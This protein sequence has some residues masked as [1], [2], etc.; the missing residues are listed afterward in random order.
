[1]VGAGL[2]G[3]V[4]LAVR[5]KRPPTPSASWCDGSVAGDERPGRPGAASRVPDYSGLPLAQTARMVTAFRG[6]L[7]TLAALL[8]LGTPAGAQDE[9]PEV[10]RLNLIGVESV[11][12]DQLSLS[13]ATQ[14]SRCRG[15]LLVPVCWITRSPIFWERHYL[16][17]RELARDIARIQAFY[18]R[19][20]WRETEVDT[21][22]APRGTNRAEVTFRIA[23]GP[24]T[25]VTQ[26]DVVQTQ[27]VLP[28][29]DLARAM[30][31]QVGQPLNLNRVDTTRFRLEQGLQERGYADA[32]V[33]TNIV[34]DEVARAATV[35]FDVNPRWI[36]TVE[37]INVLE[38]QRVSDRTILRSL[39]FSE[40]D[41]FR[42]TDL[43]RSQRNLYESNLFRRAVISPEDGP[44]DSAK[45][46]EITVT[47]APL[48]E[49]R[50]SAGFSTVDFL[51]TETR[52]THFNFMGGA[53]RLTVQG[54]IGNLL[55]EQLNDRLIF[56]NVFTIPTSDR[57]RY[58]SPTYNASV[59]LRQPWFLSSR[60]DLAANAFAS[61]RLQPGI[62]VDRSYGGA[63]TFTREIMD[64]TPVSANYRFEV[65]SVEAGDVYFCVNYGVCDQPTLVA[66]RNNQ[67]LSPFSLIGRYDRTNDPL[68]PSR[69]SR[70][71][72]DTE[73]ASQTTGSDY[74]YNRAVLEGSHFM[75]FR[76][77]GVLA[78][79]G[80]AGWV[81]ALPS[82]GTAVTGTPGRHIL[83][84]RKRFYSG[85]ANSVRGFR[86][87]QLGPRVLTIA[88]E[89]LRDAFAV[90][91]GDTVFACPSAVPIEQC[92]PGAPGLRD[93][94]FEGR[95][96]GGNVVSEAS[97]ELR[98]P[99]NRILTGAVFV[100]GGY[101]AQRVD[102]TLP[103]SRAGITPG[104]GIRYQSAIGP[105]RV[106]LGINPARREALPVITEIVENGERRLIRLES[107][108]VH[109]IAR[110][111]LAGALDRVRLH[112]SIGEAF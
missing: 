24:P 96:I 22:V 38:N 106:D 33:D 53:R 49:A 84:P 97:V 51:Q 25:I 52:F 108:R 103:S 46:V 27:D 21:A 66:L 111:G 30:A 5:G 105:I 45:V 62:F 81:E 36:A 75:Q 43:L 1:M 72:I 83:H 104:F 23:E 34:V 54:A 14:Q 37:A 110:T 55:A 69:G 92:D 11:D 109:S 85:G 98:F 107:Q 86:E 79:R 28:E 59:E 88:P 44:A 42:L 82:T 41:I 10:T 99:L 60:N 89:R 74:R 76:R 71:R 31:L 39:T 18:W 20:G 9:N 90:I 70:L 48:R 77:R 65:T 35:R 12:R 2:P 58:L 13:I 56:A 26:L 100:D 17:R 16:D 3:L 7:V 68:G 94:D 101:V 87:N 102:A 19:R 29:R 8:I 80:R 73:H 93:G 47:E 63:A 78:F 50:I 91:N 40:G 61:R 57:S 95:P 4:G 32:I 67:R 64:R 6:G 15:F 112:L